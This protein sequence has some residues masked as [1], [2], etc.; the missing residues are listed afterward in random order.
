MTLLAALCILKTHISSENPG[1]N[2]LSLALFFLLM[3]MFG[4]PEA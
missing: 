4:N 3:H 1:K 2:I